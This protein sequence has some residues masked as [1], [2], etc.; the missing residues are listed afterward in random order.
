MPMTYSEIIKDIMLERG[1]SQ[2]EFAKMIGVHQTTVGQWILGKKKPGFDS[3]LLIYRHFG[4]TPN[5]LMG[6]GDKAED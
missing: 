1:M 4:V 2:E 3:I 5:D 6:I